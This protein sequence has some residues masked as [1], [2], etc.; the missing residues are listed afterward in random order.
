M[1]FI[2]INY[3]KKYFQEIDNY[4]A[5]T[6]ESYAKETL[7]S[8]QLVDSLNQ[9]NKELFYRINQEAKAR[10]ESDN[11]ISLTLL[12]QELIEKYRLSYINI[13]LYMVNKDFV[14]YD[15]TFEPDLGFDLSMADDTQGYIDQCN[16]KDGI[17][18]VDGVI[19]DS[20][21]KQHKIYTFTKIK[22]DTYLEMGFVD[23]RFNEFYQKSFQANDKENKNK[24]N[25]YIVITLE[26]FQYYFELGV[27][28]KSKS[29]N[30][31]FDSIERFK[32]SAL[33]KNPVI[34]TVREKKE[35]QIEK[36]NYIYVYKSILSHTDISI[37]RDADVVVEIVVDISKI[38]K[39][40]SRFESIFFLIVFAVFLLFLFIF[41]WTKFY[42]TRP[43]NEIVKSMH[44]LKLIDDEVLLAKND[45]LGIIANEYNKLVNAITK[46]INLNKTLLVENRMFIADTVHQIRTPL[47]V[48]MMNSDLIKMSQVDDES[49]EFINQ[50]HASIN[51]LT[52]SY[53]DLAYITS[54]DS[55]E[56]KKTHVSISDILQERVDFFSTIANV[57]HKTVL[58]MIEN[59]ISYSINQIELE[60]LIDNNI[61]NA[62]KY[63][64][65][66]EPITVELEKNSDEVRLSFYSYAEP[67]K[68]ISLIFEKSYRENEEKRGLGL[69]LHMVKG[70]CEKYGV[71]YE[72]KYRNN[73]NIFTYIFEI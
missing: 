62:I 7:L 66:N 54:H 63:A 24:T 41:V 12:K 17:Y 67:I 23:K 43:T 58:V 51:M 60:R 36:G 13:E 46:E 56:Y 32:N 22:K 10:V 29:K 33:T 31:L 21:D 55:I 35:Y 6:A 40:F 52:N 69:G 1:S 15:T 11:N 71:T 37:L 4:V 25:V 70:I 28:E 27:Q 26:E 59:S 57:N 30:E 61:S 19:Y 2:Y 68:D 50:I 39:D 38:Q 20:I 47:S 72:V 42:I 73:Q 14:I 45:E 44:S 48:I 49:E 18:F 34:N 53:E 16:A 8:L 9:N 5:I 65:V 3:E 64:K